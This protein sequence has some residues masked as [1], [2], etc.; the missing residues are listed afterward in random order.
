MKRFFPVQLGAISLSDRVVHGPTAR[1]RANPGR[2]L[3][4]CTLRRSSIDID[5]EIKAGAATLR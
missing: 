2:N 4:R 3:P 1:L 5:D